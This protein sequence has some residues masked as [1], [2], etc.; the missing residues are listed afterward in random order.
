M[1]F[2]F[3]PERLGGVDLG[4]AIAGIKRREQRQHERDR[5]HCDHVGK[6]QV[7]GDF[8]DVIHLTGEELDTKNALNCRDHSPML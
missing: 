4:R 7:R 2:S 8:A 6:L 5:C 3:I 1:I